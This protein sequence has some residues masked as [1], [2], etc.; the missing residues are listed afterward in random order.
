VSNSAAVLDMLQTFLE[1]GTL[2]IV[3]ANDL[4]KLIN[5]DCGEDV[6]KSFQKL[7]LRMITTKDLNESQRSALIKFMKPR[8]DVLSRAVLR[9]LEAK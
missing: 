6:A 2:S 8:N 7:V 4:L 1:P 3:S 9:D 5:H